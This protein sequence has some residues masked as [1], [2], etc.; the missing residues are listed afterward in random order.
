VRKVIGLE[1]NDVFFTV[2]KFTDIIEEFKNCPN[3]LAGKKLKFSFLGNNP[4]IF[5]D[6]DRNVIYDENGRPL[7]SHAGLATMMANM[8]GFDYEFSFT[9]GA[10][11]YDNKTGTWMGLTGDV[12]ERKI[13]FC[14][15]L[16]FALKSFFSIICIYLKLKLHILCLKN[17]LEGLGPGV[18]KCCFS[19]LKYYFYLKICKKMFCEL[20]NILNLDALCMR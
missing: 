10:N 7:G 11:Y 14:N 13:T 3:P 8:Y 18:L 2:K 15:I 5:T 20:L 6:F 16:D 17:P 12:S 1:D 4:D 19:T 9:N